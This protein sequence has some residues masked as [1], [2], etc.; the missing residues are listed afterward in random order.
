MLSLFNRSKATTPVVVSHDI[1]QEKQ[2]EIARL[3]RQA[4]EAVDL[5][6]RT[7]NNLQDINQQIDSAVDEIDSYIQSLTVTRD[8]MFS[9][10]DNNAAII[11][12]FSKL[13]NIGTEKE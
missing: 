7:I 1:L 3:T 6:S 9:Q 13:L 8:T 10:R 4:D 2:N 11:A 5:V 12:N